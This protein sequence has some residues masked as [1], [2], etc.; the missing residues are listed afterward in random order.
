M[1]ER[2]DSEDDLDPTLDGGTGSEG[3]QII[4]NA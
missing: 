3:N 1:D 2:L 4:V